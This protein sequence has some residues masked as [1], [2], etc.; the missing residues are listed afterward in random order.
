MARGG[1]QIDRIEPKLERSAGLLKRSA[2][3]RVK[4]MPA[5]LAGVSALGFNPEPLGSALALGALEALPEANFKQV[6]QAGF[7]IGKLLEELADREGRLAHT[8]S[9]TAS[10]PMQG[11]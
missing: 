7:V 3:S 5:K 10:L 8:T 6:V 4:V 11:G 2:D 9:Y 1:E